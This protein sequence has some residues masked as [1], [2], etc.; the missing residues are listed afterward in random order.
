MTSLAADQD[1]WQGWGTIF[2]VVL[3]GA[4]PTLTMVICIT[5]LHQVV[6]ALVMMH[7]VCMGLLTALFITF[8][9]AWPYY[10][11][12]MKSQLERWPEQ[13]GWSIVAF[14]VMVGACFIGY[15]VL[16]CGGIFP[17]LCMPLRPKNIIQEGFNYSETNAWLVGMYF[18]IVNPVFEEF[19][20]RLVLY[21]ELGGRLFALDEGEFLPLRDRVATAE[22][23]SPRQ[24]V[25]NAAA[26]GVAIDVSPTSHRDVEG[27]ATCHD[28]AGTFHDVRLSEVGKMVVSMFYGTYHVVVVY[29][30]V[31]TLYAALAFVFLTMF[32]R[33]LIICRNTKS[34]GILTATAAHSGLDL[35]VVLAIA[36]VLFYK[37]V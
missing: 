24:P 28:S 19:F 23:P 16:K 13:L 26:D 3:L 2:I 5:G 17:W 25:G 34:L 37:W 30:L 31:N 20:W 27:G 6:L 15:A 8:T 18:T 33:L 10:N 1:G 11:G 21:R 29:H 9:S 7:W 22:S 14:C 4:A 36:N 12:L 32:G 35:G